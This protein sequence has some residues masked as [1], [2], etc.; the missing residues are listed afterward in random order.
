MNMNETPSGSRYAIGLFGRRNAGKSSLI[1]AL[2]GQPIAVTSEV[3]GTT[4]DPVRKAMELLPIGPVL[5]IDTAGL[6]DEG[7][8]GAK[9]VEKTYEELRRCS[10]ALVVADF[11]QGVTAFEAELLAQ[12]NRRRIPA[13]LVLTNV[14]PLCPTRPSSPK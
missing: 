14:T 3:P 2:A 1:N 8:L 13:I 4:T 9:R 12:L 5:L 10:L 7:D 6:D 11:T